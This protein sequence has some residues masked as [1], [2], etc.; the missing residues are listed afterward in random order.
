MVKKKFSNQ[1]FT[2]VKDLSYEFCI[3]LNFLKQIHAYINGTLVSTNNSL[4]KYANCIQF[5]L[6][7]PKSY[8]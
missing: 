3:L 6:M 5:G 8:K 1:T 7:T 4:L 2:T